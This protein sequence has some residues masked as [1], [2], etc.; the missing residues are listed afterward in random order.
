MT[1]L[2]I[3]I[4]YLLFFTNFFAY[5]FAYFFPA[6]FKKKFKNLKIFKIFKF[7]NFFKKRR[8]KFQKIVLK[9]ISKKSVKKGKYMI[10]MTNL[11]IGMKK[12]ISKKKKFLKNGFSKKSKMSNCGYTTDFFV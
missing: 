7:S 10:S 9:K 6:F 11:V 3:L 8:E 12:K 1:K 2:V 5:F 4:M